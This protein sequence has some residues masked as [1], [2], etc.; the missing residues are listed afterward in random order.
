MKVIGWVGVL[1]IVILIAW[2]I[3]NSVFSIYNPVS[4]IHTE[5]I[6]EAGI[7]YYSEF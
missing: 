3:I 6:A 2:M 4:L 7:D 5:S 1:H